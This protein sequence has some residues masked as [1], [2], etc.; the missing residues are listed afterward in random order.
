MSR[1]LIAFLLAAL[2]FPGAG[3]FYLKRRLRGLLFLLPTL[4]AL[5]VLGTRVIGTASDLS[6]RVA[7]GSLPLDPTAL[8]AEIARQGDLTTPAISMASAVLVLAWIAGIV[9]TVYLARSAP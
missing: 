9:D 3:H 7:N 2:A 8:A 4:A 5:A 1:P 6:E